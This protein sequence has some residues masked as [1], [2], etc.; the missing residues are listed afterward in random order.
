MVSPEVLYH[1]PHWFYHHESNH[2]LMLMQGIILSP[3]D[4]KCFCIN[5][6]PNIVSQ[7]VDQ[8]R[9]NGQDARSRRTRG[10]TRVVNREVSHG[11]QENKD[12]YQLSDSCLFLS[13]SFKFFLTS[14]KLSLMN[15]H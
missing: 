6:L 2:R 5:L 14:A 1:I 13:L 7:A 12:G 3:Q 11:D 15:P 8:K 10:P 9:P 4:C